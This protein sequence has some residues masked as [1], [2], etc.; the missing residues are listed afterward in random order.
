MGVIAKVHAQD[1]PL[2]AD[3]AERGLLQTVCEGGGSDLCP[4]LC[5][6]GAPPAVDHSDTAGV[7]DVCAQMAQAGELSC[8]TIDQQL[9]PGECAGRPP[10]SAE[11]QAPSFWSCSVLL[12]LDG[13]CAHDLSADDPSIG[14]STRVSDVCP[15]ECSGHIGC[16][17]A[18]LDV[19]FM[20]R[21]DDSSGHES[22]LE[23]GGSGCVDSGGATFD[24][25][26]WVRAPIETEYA[27][28]GTYSIAMW[29]LVHP[30]EIEQPAVRSIDDE[31]EVLFSHHLVSTDMDTNVDEGNKGIR[32]GVSRD[33]W[34]TAWLAVV[35]LSTPTDRWRSVFQVGFM[36]DEVPMWTHLVVVIEEPTTSL[37]VDGQSIPPVMP[38]ERHST[39]QMDAFLSGVVPGCVAAYHNHPILEQCSN[40]ALGRPTTQST[41]DSGSAH[42]VDGM[43]CD[44]PSSEFCTR[45][46]GTG[47]TWWQVDLGQATQVVAVGIINPPGLPQRLSLVGARIIVHTF[48]D[49]FGTA[50]AH[51]CGVVTD[52]EVRSQPLIIKECEMDA[53]GQYVTIQQ[54]DNTVL[55]LCEC[56][57]LSNCSPP[58]TRERL[59]LDLASEAWIGNDAGESSGRGFRGT[60]S[61]LQV[62]ASAIDPS[63]V[64]CVYQSGRSLIQS[65]RNDLHGD[66]ECR[67]AFSSGCTSPFADNRDTNLQ[68]TRSRAVVDDG[69]CMFAARGRRQSEASSVRVT[70]QWQTVNLQLQYSRPPVIFC[71]V[72][73]RASTTLAMPRIRRVQQ[74]QGR[75]Y[76][77][78]IRLEQKSCHLA[79][80]PDTVETLSILAT[81]PGISEEGW[82]TSALRV[83][84]LEWHR[85]SLLQS[86]AQEP[87]IVAQAQTY[88]HRTR[89]VSAGIHQPQVVL[90]V[91]HVSFLLKV[92]GE[93]V[94]CGDGDYYAEYFDN[95]DLDRLDY[96]PVVTVCETGPIDWRWHGGGGGG[97]PAVMLGISEAENPE[98]FSVRWKS[99]ISVMEKG[100]DY[101]FTSTAN[102]GARVSLNGAMVIDHWSECCASFTSD[103]MDLEAGQ[104]YEVTYEYRSAL[105]NSDDPIDSYCSLSWSGNG[106]SFGAGSTTGNSSISGAPSVFADVGWLA[107][108][109]G[110]AE[111]EGV[112]VLSGHTVLDPDL[113]TDID[114]DGT[115]ANR[116]PLLFAAVVSASRFSSHL[117]MLESSGQSM[118]LLLEHDSCN[119]VALDTTGRIGWL[120][121]AADEAPLLQRLTLSSDLS[122]LLA[123][124]GELGLPSYLRWSNGSDPCSDR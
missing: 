45:V 87:V 68:A 46:V 27:R 67:M 60:I 69:S 11:P 21:A 113:V 112:D 43:G 109:T 80:P 118:S 12:K 114:Y 14:A 86:F 120:M 29:V 79:L 117:R 82:Q 55:E 71:G 54:N 6:G 24:G 49:D 92:T 59:S 2:C 25:G 38:D 70:D 7:A 81:E 124:N 50:A 121:V 56:V 58:P 123:V 97:V 108:Q 104:L 10:P 77:F 32:I 61:M 17:P 105:S 41:A 22:A 106:R 84:D 64:S 65:G 3:L 102:P 53:V 93:G 74:T 95:I 62:F 78:D 18:V 99:R 39:P 5:A 30:T 9:C 75:S 1:Q 100:S 110:S 103:P 8:A 48:A 72:I 122:A 23:L 33:R 4:E 66:S 36:R 101:T 91:P 13:G 47:P 28:E 37:F 15:V 34:L 96:T 85:V 115:F 90:S 116:V 19:S 94:W 51:I 52:D 73:T 76:S 89:F 111:I 20:G 16:V 26:G 88:D 119:A 44:A 57:V 31:I 98:L 83:Q 40:V 42:A 107:V 35:D 63:G